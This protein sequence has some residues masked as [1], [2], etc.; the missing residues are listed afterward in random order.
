[1]AGVL[2]GGNP[3]DRTS[4][5]A[6]EWP[7]RTYQN[8]NPPGNKKMKFTNTDCVGEERKGIWV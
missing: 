2:A 4:E 5:M 6:G 8:Q 7:N 1:M 3:S